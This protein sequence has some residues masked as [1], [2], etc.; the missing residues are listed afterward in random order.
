[1]KASTTCPRCGSQDVLPITYGLPGPELIEE[2]LAGRVTLGGCMI[3]PESPNRLCRN[4]GRDWREGE[5]G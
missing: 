2:S 3:G 5:G 1:M 4:C